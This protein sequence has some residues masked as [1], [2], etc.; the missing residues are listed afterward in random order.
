MADTLFPLEPTEEAEKQHLGGKPRVQQ[1][2]RE[3]M[4]WQILDLDSLV[5][6]DHEVR[7]VWELAQQMDLSGLYA[8]IQA[9]EGHAGRSAIDPR[10]LF[11]LWLYATKEGVGSARALAR[12]CEEHIAYLWICGGVTV[13]YHTL[14]DFRVDHEEVLDQLLTQSIASLQAEGLIEIK[15]VADD[16]M[17]VRASAGGASCRREETLEKQLE[18]AKQQVETLKKELKEHPE[19]TSKRQKAA[20]QRAVQEREEKIGKALQNLEKIKQKQQKNLTEKQRQKKKEPRCSTTDPEARNMKM[21][22]GGF[23]MA[24]NV[25]LAST[26]KSQII[27]GVDVTNEGSDKGLA[28]PMVEQIEERTKETPEEFMVDGGFVSK[29]DFEELDKKNI[30]IY[31]PVPK[32]RK[33]GQDPYEPR[34]DDSPAIAKWRQRMATEEAKE[35]YKQRAATAECVN[36]IQRNRGLQ[37][38]RVRGIKKVKAVVLWFAILHNLLRGFALRTAA[39]QA[40]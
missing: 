32:A 38:F 12:L 10:I 35:I 16:G 13:N 3:Q 7:L 33:E 8:P 40:V 11:A 17:R 2:S 23:N 25:Q 1:A 39:L 36:A 22:N 5:P 31:A 24:Y 18:K 4:A 19:A 28:S 9:V 26:P 29:E 14:A 34:S 6:E 37:A 21:A 30:A 15:R 27:V 20:R